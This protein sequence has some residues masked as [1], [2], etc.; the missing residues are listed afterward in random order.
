VEAMKISSFIVREVAKVNIFAITIKK[1]DI[2]C[3]DGVSNMG[4]ERNGT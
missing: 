2:K 3:V 1:G 4:M